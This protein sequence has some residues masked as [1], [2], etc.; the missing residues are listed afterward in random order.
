MASRTPF[1][2]GI[3]GVRD[4]KGK[5]YDNTSYVVRNLEH[6]LRQENLVFENIEV[7][8]G[9]GRGVEDIVVKWCDSKAIN[10]RK[11]PPNIQE[12]GHKR[13]FATRN[14]A[15]VSECDQLIVFWDGRIDVP[16]ESI[17]TAMHLGKKATVL[18]VIAKE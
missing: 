12:Y 17:A 2:L 18:P 16:V 11:I 5:L 15:I 9:G 13:A 7:V 10:C 6:Y 3:V 14:N 4:Y 1:I 8:T